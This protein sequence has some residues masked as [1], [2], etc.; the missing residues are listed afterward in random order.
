[1][2]CTQSL[3]IHKDGTFF[4]P[5]SGCLD[6]GL[7]QAVLRHRVVVSCQFVRALRCPVCNADVHRR[8]EGAD[9]VPKPGDTPPV[10]PGTAVVHV[11]GSAGCSE[12][13]CGP[14]A[15]LGIWLAGHGSVRSCNSLERRCALCAG[16]QSDE[17]S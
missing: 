13:G 6:G 8:G 17:A 16:S 9:E 14:T 5:G 2:S 1:M 3:V 11:D 10:C 7:S 4:C 12:P 15:S